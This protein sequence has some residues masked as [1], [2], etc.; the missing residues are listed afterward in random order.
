MYQARLRSLP[1]RLAEDEV[2][3][4]ISM[5]RE[6]VIRGP[7]RKPTLADLLDEGAQIVAQARPL[8]G[9]L[10]LYPLGNVAA[11][12]HILRH[13]PDQPPPSAPPSPTTHPQTCPA[14]SRTVTPYPPVG[15]DGSVSSD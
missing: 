14:G 13:E 12:A 3:A 4:V 5:T 7:E 15:Y 6:Q 2:Q 11:L 10:R 1:R 9:R 8:D